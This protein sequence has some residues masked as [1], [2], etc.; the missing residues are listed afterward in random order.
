[1]D[2]KRRWDYGLRNVCNTK[3]GH[4]ESHNEEREEDEEV[5]LGGMSS[6][7]SLWK[8]PREYSS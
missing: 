4:K 6:P 7:L 3:E 2:F 8:T 1:M 5:A